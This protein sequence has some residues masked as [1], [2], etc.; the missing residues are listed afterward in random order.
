MFVG[1]FIPKTIRKIIRLFLIRID[2]LL[3]RKTS[4]ASLVVKITPGKLRSPSAVGVCFFAHFDPHNHIDPYVVYYLKAL[5]KC[6]FDI[7]FCTSSEDIMESDYHNLKSFCRTIIVRKNQSLDFGSWKVG[8]ENTPDWLDYPKV[9]FTND[10]IFGPIFDL[11][12]TMKHSNLPSVEL[13]GIADSYQYFHHLQSW[14]L[15]FNINTRTRNFLESFWSNFKFLKSKA[16]IIRKYEIGFSREAVRAK[17]Q[18]HAVCEYHLAKTKMPE[19]SS[20]KLWN[21]THDFWKVLITDLKCPFIKREL[22]Q[23]NPHNI[24]DISEWQTVLQN[25][26]AYDP[27]LIMAFLRRFKPYS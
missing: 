10:S 7:V 2:C 16:N 13:L 8:I 24:K 6:G 21:P 22:I 1:F 27:E 11:N 26:T 25:N 12:K 15:L 18:L 23:K 4:A 19:L 3:S 17:I 20:K 9:L 5:A 14:F